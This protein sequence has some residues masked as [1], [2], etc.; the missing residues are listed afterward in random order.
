VLIAATCWSRRLETSVIDRSTGVGA[1]G[2]D[3]RRIG[4]ASGDEASCVIQ[5]DIIRADTTNLPKKGAVRDQRLRLRRKQQQ[6][7]HGRDGET[8]LDRCDRQ[9]VDQ[10]HRQ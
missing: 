7:G 8:D 9:V 2:G 10:I 1:R 4:A 3:D 5:V 6:T